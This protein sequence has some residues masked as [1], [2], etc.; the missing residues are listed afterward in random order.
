MSYVV[1]RVCSETWTWI[2]QTCQSDAHLTSWSYE[3]CGQVKPQILSDSGLITP[4]LGRVAWDP[5][6]ILSHAFLQLLQISCKLALWPIF[7]PCSRLILETLSLVCLQFV[8]ISA[9]CPSQIPA[10]VLVNRK[11]FTLEVRLWYWHKIKLISS[12]DRTLKKMAADAICRWAPIL[13]Q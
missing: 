12:T 3:A 10:E 2:R 5:S 6:A 4:P 1:R 11:V 13:L 7:L 9:Y 8:L